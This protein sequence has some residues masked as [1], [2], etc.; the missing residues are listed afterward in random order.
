MMVGVLFRL[1]PSGM[2]DAFPNLD[3]YVA[4]GTGRPAFQRAFAAQ[5]VVHQAAQAG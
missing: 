5:L 2:L 1:R 3:A 4:R